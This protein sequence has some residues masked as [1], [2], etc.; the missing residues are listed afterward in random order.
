[1][2]SLSSYLIEELGFFDEKLLGLI[3]WNDPAG[4]SPMSLEEQ[5]RLYALAQ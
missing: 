2:I 1:M 3:D 4:P 5:K